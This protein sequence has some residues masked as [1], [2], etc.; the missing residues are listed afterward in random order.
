[1]MKKVMAAAMSVLLL[2]GCGAKNNAPANQPAETAQAS[3]ASV[4]VTSFKTIGD[5]FAA[6]PDE[7][8]RGNTEDTYFIVFDLNGTLYRAYADLTKDVSD[9]L[10]ALEFDDP[11]YEEKHRAIASAL[12]IRQLDNLTEMIPSQDELDKLIGKTGQELIDD[13]WTE[14]FGYNLA[15][16]DVYMNH[17][18]FSYIVRFEKDKDYQNTDD[19]D[20]IATI[21][22]LKV[23]SVTYDGIGNGSEIN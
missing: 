10:M 6:N 16:M 15:D 2:A 8:E 4:D 23:I 17:G 5:I 21:A 7:R 22:P 19:F 3:N 20:I 1:M 12:E 14:G 11:K 18:P 13:G 9:Q